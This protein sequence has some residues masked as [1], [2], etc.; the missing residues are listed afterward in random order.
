MG[1]DWWDDN[2]RD[3]FNDFW[4]K[5]WSGKLQ[6]DDILDVVGD[7]YP[8]GTLMDWFG[9]FGEW[10]GGGQQGPPPEYPDIEIAGASVPQELKDYYTRASELMEQ[11]AEYAKQANTRSDVL[12]KEY[13]KY[14][15][16]G[17]RRWT[18]AAFAGFPVQQA[19]GESVADI[20]QSFTKA[21]Q[22]RDREL[23]GLGLD[24]SSPQYASTQ[25]EMAVA[26]AAAE[27]GARNQ[28]RKYVRDLNDK[29]RLQAIELGRALIPEQRAQK[30]QAIE[31]LSQAGATGGRGA[32]IYGNAWATAAQLNTRASIA[33]AEL[34]MKKYETDMAMRAQAQQSEDAMWGNIFGLAGTAAGW[35]FGGPAGGAVGGQAGRMVGQK[36]SSGSQSGL[37]ASGTI[38]YGGDYLDSWDGDY[39]GYQ[40]STNPTTTPAGSSSWGGDSG[41]AWG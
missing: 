30:A 5:T 17:E 9:E 32:Q 20:T 33:N 14:Y 10:M 19:L 31:G 23:R 25:S 37:G 26:R 3:P 40:I 29:R 4:D 41:M 7:W 38:G 35:Y 1:W 13:K 8:I 24:P 16:P 28:A 39:G 27:A 6:W 22:S 2:V 12:W 36:F 21:K 15:R 11:Q 18:K 34:A